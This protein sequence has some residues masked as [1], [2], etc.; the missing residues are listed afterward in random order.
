MRFAQRFTLGF[1]LIIVSLVILVFGSPER[2]GADPSPALAVAFCVVFAIGF[3][4]AA[5]ALMGAE[6]DYPAFLSGLVLYFIVGALIAVFTYVNSSRLGLNTLDDA[7]TGA[8]WVY[9]IRYAAMWPIEVV[10]SA[11]ILGYDRLIWD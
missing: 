10:R 9:W 4:V 5:M 6:K 11:G 7:G 1:A 3:I 2:T 8:F